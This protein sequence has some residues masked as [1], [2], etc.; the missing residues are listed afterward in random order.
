MA[1][2]GASID[3]VAALCVGTLALSFGAPT[4][5]IETTA[6]AAG[7]IGFVLGRQKKFGPE[8]KRVR[9]RIQTETLAAFKKLASG[10]DGTTYSQADLDAADAA[11]S[12]AL[13]TSFLDRQKLAESAV[14]GKGFPDKAVEIIM[15][16][17]GIAHP[18]IFSQKQRET[19]PYRYAV[20]VVTLGI[21]AAVDNPDYYRQLEPTLSF[22]MAKALGQVRG[23][24]KRIESGVAVADVAPRS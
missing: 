9:R 21:K 16:G 3:K 2:F 22:E 4:G 23:G 1:D 5:A 12:K 20:N 11:L 18:E 19:L 24:I 17:L 10:S 6:A 7:L 13:E 15:T 14:T 8:C